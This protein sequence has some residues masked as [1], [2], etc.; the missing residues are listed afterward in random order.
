MIRWRNTASDDGYSNAD[1]WARNWC[2]RWSLAWLAPGRECTAAR[3]TMGADG[4][5]AFLSD[6]QLPAPGGRLV[7]AIRVLPQGL[8]GQDWHR[9][10]TEAGLTPEVPQACDPIPGHVLFSTR[11]QILE[12]G[13]LS[14]GGLLA[15]RLRL[16]DLERRPLVVMAKASCARMWF[17]LGADPLPMPLPPGT[18]SLSEMA[19]AYGVPVENVPELADELVQAGALR[20]A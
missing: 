11:T 17:P 3:A 7:F 1:L 5:A 6:L 9:I 12:Q 16:D 20:L 18:T 14:V 8:E 2:Q 10:W 15:R 13:Y 4:M 19:R